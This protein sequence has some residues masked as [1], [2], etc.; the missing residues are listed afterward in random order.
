MTQVLRSRYS[1]HDL[2]MVITEK[3]SLKNMQGSLITGVLSTASA[4]AGDCNKG[5]LV[6]IWILI[7]IHSRVPG[8]ESGHGPRTGINLSA[9]STYKQSFNFRSIV[10]PEISF[11]KKTLLIITRATV[12][13]R[14]ILPNSARNL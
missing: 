10:F 13:T 4:T 12:F 14:Q 1:R 11:H 7:W 3:Q 6:A 2:Y 8:S 5:N 9:Y